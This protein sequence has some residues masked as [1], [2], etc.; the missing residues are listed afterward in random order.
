[1]K[2]KR[3]ALLMTLC[4]VLLVVTSVMGTIAYLTDKDQVK[5]TFTVGKV[6]ITLDEALVNEDGKPI[7]ESNAVVE[8]LADAKR[9]EENSYH[10]LPGH[11]YT[12]DPT[13]TVKA[14]SEESYVRMMVR[15][16]FTKNLTGKELNM[17]LD[18]II[19][20]YNEDDWKLYQDRLIEQ[21][22]DENP[23]TTITYQ[24]RYKNTV[25]GVD[26]A[27]ADADNKLPAL[28]TDIQVPNTWDNAEMEAIGGFTVEVEAH[29]IQA[30]GFDTADAAWAAF[31]TQTA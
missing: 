24:Y 26:A 1:M 19:A 27:G 7:N 21:G 14:G 5:N 17:N 2:T 20:G 29:A 12:K 23:Y 8:D 10:L 22:T 3:K 31:S 15:V 25:A 13:V 11:S 18:S 30:S 16:K 28:F 4:A 6:D 9:V